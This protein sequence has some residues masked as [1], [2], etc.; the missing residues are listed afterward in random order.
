MRRGADVPGSGYRCPWYTDGR[1][2]SGCRRPSRPLGRNRATQAPAYTPTPTQTRVPTPVSEPTATPVPTVTLAPTSSPTPPATQGTHR[3]AVSNSDTGAYPSSY[4][5][6]GAYAHAAT[7]RHASHASRDSVAHGDADT[8]ARAF[9]AS[10]GGG[11][12]APTG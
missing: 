4:K 1:S 5:H 7:N 8:A 6:A 12:L 10:V 3:H 2:R 9:G 11:V